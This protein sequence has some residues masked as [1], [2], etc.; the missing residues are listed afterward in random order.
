M[1]TDD[2][3]DNK[4]TSI[5]KQ[6]YIETT[7]IPQHDGKRFKYDADL[8]RQRLAG[9]AKL[10]DVLMILCA[11]FALISD[12]YQ[13]NVMSMLNKVFAIE[14]PKEYTASMSTSVS[15]A[16]LVGT[17]LGQVAIGLTCDYL[18]R[19]WSII[20]ATLFLILGTVL[21]AAAHGATVNGMF[22]MLIICRGV[23]G[24]GIGAEYP[25]SSVTA[26]EAANE[27]V[28]RR[29]G[30]FILC[31]NLPLSFGGPFALIIFLIVHKITG[32]HYEGLWRTMFAIGAFWPLSI[33]YF[34]LKMST[35]VLYKKSAIKQV[36]PYWLAIK[37]YWPRMIG[38]MVAWFLYDF[39]T[40]PNGI[41]SAGIIANVI[42][43]SEKNNLELIAEWNLLIGALALPGVFI[44]AY[45]NDVIG[46]KYTIMLG[47]SGYIVF[48]L[49][50]GLAYNKVKHIT[51]LFIVLYGLMMSCGNMGPGDGMGLI[52]SESYATPIRGT[53]YGLSA[54]IGKVGAVVGTKTF[55]PIQTNLGDRWTFIIAAICGLAG[56]LVTFFFIP[57]L[58]EEDLLEED[59]KFKNYLLENGWKGHFGIPSENNEEEDLESTDDD[60]SVK[61]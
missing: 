43:A 56:V 32:K 34:R 22:W 57:H 16:S 33:F 38:T 40:F 49:I 28:R 30:A 17:I 14:Y 36:A 11:G 15:N 18:G 4:N 19:K 26:S 39:V 58:K 6:D 50:V 8:R 46:R 24:F 21:C 48:G 55:T 5:V 44:G 10:K 27:S 35:S 51:A 12:G 9:G 3:R 41:F 54:A 60:F 2:L 37:Y 61:K 47:F 31:T 42:P 59:V 23:T 7:E 25:S 45:L 52:S 13:N 20:T 1:N 53:A 29:G